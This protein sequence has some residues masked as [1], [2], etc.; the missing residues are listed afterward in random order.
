MTYRAKDRD[1][2]WNTHELKLNMLSELCTK[3]NSVNRLALC[4]P[5]ENQEEFVTKLKGLLE[6]KLIHVSALFK[7]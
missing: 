5:I 1:G 2:T 6:N 7:F 4:L 3:K